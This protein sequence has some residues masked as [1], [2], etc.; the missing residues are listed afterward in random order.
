MPQRHPT[1]RGALLFFT[2]SLS[3]LFSLSPHASVHA[4]SFAPVLTVQPGNAFVEGKALYIASGGTVAGMISSQIFMVDLSVSWNATSPVYK[5]LPSGPGS[6]WFPSAMSPDG[7]KWF[8]FVAGV[9]HVFDTQTNQWSQVLNYPDGKFYGHAAATDPISGKTLIPFGY[10]N[11]DGTWSMLVVDLKDNSIAS[12]NRNFT[13]PNQSTY[14]ATWNTLLKNLL[15]VTDGTMHTYNL[16]EGWKNFTAPQGIQASDAYCMVSS[17]SGS[18]VVLFGGYSKSLNATVGDIFVL[19]V[20]TLTWKKGPSTPPG[21]VRRSPAC[22]ISN[23]YFVSWGGD[24]GNT[25]TIVPPQNVMLVYDLKTDTWTS[26]YVPAPTTPPAITNP[27]VQPSGTQSIVPTTTSTTSAA[28]K[29]NASAWS[30]NMKIVAGF[31]CVLLAIQ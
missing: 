17:A 20:P 16:V 10:K 1:L 23:D 13:A 6:N 15:V 31:V 25:A 5:Q 4:Q 22:A 14:A 9:G 21:D 3:V 19:D 2:C 7:L 27:P 24:T 8:V 26:N 12:D 29:E 18:K 30:R 11:P 28:S